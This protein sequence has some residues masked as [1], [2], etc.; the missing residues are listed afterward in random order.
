M[1]SREWED[2][3]PGW[4][5]HVI[6]LDENDPRTHITEIVEWLEKNI[7]KIERHCMY[8]WNYDEF[9]VKFRYDRDYIMC[10]LRW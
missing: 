2:I 8:T 7:Q 5:E 9:K 1:I 3:K 6:K 10:S 4:Y